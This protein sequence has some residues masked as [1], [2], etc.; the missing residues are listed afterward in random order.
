MT[1][2][3]EHR[4]DA[5]DQAYL[6]RLGGALIAGVMPEPVVQRILHGLGKR[7]GIALSAT[8]T[9]NGVLTVDDHAG[10][11]VIAHKTSG[12]YRFDQTAAVHDLVDD[13]RAGHISAAEGNARLDAIDAMPPSVN[14]AGRFLGFFLIALGLCLNQ[15]PGQHELIVTAVL[16]VVVGAILATMPRWGL[17][18]L[19]APLL[20]A[21]LAAFIGASLEKAG[22]LHAPTQVVIPLLAS[23]V[24]GA[25]LAV[26][27]L[28]MSM[29]AVH[30]GAGRLIGGVHQLL[31]LSFGIVIGV[32]A[33]P[34]HWD[35]H[36]ADPRISGW[37][38]LLGVL[39]YSVGAW[40]AF[41]A[42]RSA[43]WSFAPVIVVAWGTQ[44]LVGAYAGAYA[45][46]FAGAVA[47]VLVAQWISRLPAGAPAL[48]TV[49]PLFRL[50]APGGL[51]LVGLA[52]L[53]SGDGPGED[54]GAIVYTFM[55][56][57]LGLAAGLA[58]TDKWE[59]RRVAR[60]GG[61]LP[62]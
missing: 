43:L 51:S 33:A 9:S 28:E 50:L 56:V 16:A 15:S 57:G 27:S 25:A 42:P 37:W 35:L 26:A 10:R 19:L 14:T 17:L 3:G 39:L 49:N 24:P 8:V 2:D 61:G 55:A 5:V 54:V 1:G 29:G 6:T 60:A 40:L 38:R 47:G 21:F 4:G 31:L 41:C 44:L 45:A 12:A 59:R 7:H 53:T 11:S 48:I 13:S 36:G 34:S 18:A 52:S 23:F 46:S 30:A 62:S 58:L 22:Y 32:A 20:A